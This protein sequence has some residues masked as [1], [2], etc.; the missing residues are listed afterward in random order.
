MKQRYKAMYTNGNSLEWIDTHYVYAPTE[1][2]AQLYAVAI[3]QELQ[4]KGICNNIKFL[5][6]VKG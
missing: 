5:T 1:A 4:A 6:V 2:I 3:L